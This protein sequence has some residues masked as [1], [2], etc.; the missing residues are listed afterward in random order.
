MLESVVRTDALL[1]ALDAEHLFGAGLDVTDPEPLPADHPLLFRGNVIVTPHIGS[2]G[3]R[4]RE[5]L[6]GLAVSNLRSVLA[7]EAPANRVV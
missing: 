4:T 7:G 3:Q 1:D 6:V 2:A 5:A